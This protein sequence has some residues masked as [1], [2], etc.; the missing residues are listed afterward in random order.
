MQLHWAVS[1]WAPPRFVLI[2][3]F[4]LLL[5]DLLLQFCVLKKIF[6]FINCARYIVQQI[7]NTRIYEH[8]VGW[9][10]S[11]IRHTHTHRDTLKITKRNC[12]ILKLYDTCTLLLANFHSNSFV[13]FVGIFFFL[14]KSA[15]ATAATTAEAYRLAV[16]LNGGLVRCCWVIAIRSSLSTCERQTV[17]FHLIII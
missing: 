13:C 16:L 4:L 1:Y 11:Y 7:E 6:F 3:I 17:L 10:H 8:H 15:A 9:I 2:F 14:V 12:C 5:F